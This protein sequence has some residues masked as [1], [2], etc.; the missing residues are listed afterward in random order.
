MLLI[1]ETL[2]NEIFVSRDPNVEDFLEDIIQWIRDK[3]PHLRA[4]NVM[5]EEDCMIMNFG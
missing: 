1:S 3:N 5:K 2:F 4:R